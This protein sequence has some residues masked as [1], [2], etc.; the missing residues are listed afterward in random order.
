MS[1]A[2]LSLWIAWYLP[3]LTFAVFTKLFNASNTFWL[4]AVICIIGFLVILKYLP[5]TKGI[6]MEKLEKMLVKSSS[7]YSH[8]EYWYK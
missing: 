8:N 2:T 7:Q 5:K 1:V 3:P 4:Y 6:S